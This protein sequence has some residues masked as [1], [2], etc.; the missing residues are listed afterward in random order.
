MGIGTGIFLAA[1]GAILAFGVRDNLSDVDLTAIGY[2]LI[3][4]G[5]VSVLLDLLL[6]APRRRSSTVVE[7]RRY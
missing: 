5:V 3:V 4:A 6:F 1:I 7:E 2:I